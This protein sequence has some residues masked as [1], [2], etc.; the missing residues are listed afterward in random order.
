MKD[1]HQ[2]VTKF[3]NSQNRVTVPHKNYPKATHKNGISHEI[4]FKVIQ[5]IKKIS[6]EPKKTSEE[7]KMMPLDK[8]LKICTWNDSTHLVF[9]HLIEHE[10]FSINQIKLNFNLLHRLQEIDREHANAMK[11]INKDVL[12]LKTT[13]NI[14]F[15]DFRGLFDPK[16]TAKLF[17]V[18]DEIETTATMSSETFE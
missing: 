6:D 11:K 2:N 12:S 9:D 5:T 1:N 18:L 17:A 15:N 14:V 7:V 8:P 16:S 13:L 10:Q 3:P 4:D